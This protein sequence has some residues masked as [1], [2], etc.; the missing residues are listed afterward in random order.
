MTDAGDDEGR[1]IGRRVVL[2]L[3]AL[4]GG[5]VAAGTWVS[6]ALG[7]LAGSL[8]SHDPTGISSLIPGS[9]WR[10]Y[11]VTNSFP[12]RPPAAYRLAITGN[13]DHELTLTVADLQA[14]PRTRLTRDF[15]CVTGWRV[16][17][18]RWE[19][20]RLSTLLDEAGVE[21]GQSA[22]QFVSY[23][24]TY[25]ESLTMTQARRGDVLVVDTLDGKPIGRAHGGPVRLLVAP[26]YGYKSCKWLGEI[27]ITERVLPGYWEGLGYDQDAW[28]GRSNG[29]DDA[30]V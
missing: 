26:M 21:A 23:D 27:R 30:P 22:V 6:Q 3:L 13:V 24:G 16:R 10:Y 9:G 14:R 20:V 18:V 17:G 4:G 15:Q 1:P 5:T 29:R 25:T 12:Y 11:S 19:G 8:S 28:I 2:G 7:S